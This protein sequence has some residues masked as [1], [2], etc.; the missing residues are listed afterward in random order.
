VSKIIGLWLAVAGGLLTTSEPVRADDQSQIQAQASAGQTPQRAADTAP[1]GSALEEIL[2]TATKT[3]ETSL[4][5]TPL[6]I[7]VFSVERLNDSA[8]LNVKDLVAMTPNL[9]VAQTTANAQIYI[10]GI[11]SNNVFNGSDPDVTVQIDGVYLARAYSQFTDFIDVDRIEVLRG[12]QGTLYGRNAVGG[13]INIISRK[14]SDQFESKVQVTGGTFDLVEAQAYVSGPIIPGTLQASL[15]GNYLNHDDYVDNVVPGKPGVGNADRG[16]LRG[17]LR[18]LPVDNVEMITRADWKKADERYDSFSHVLAPL[19]FAPLAR[20]TVGDYTR[21]A[22]DNPQ[23]LQSKD[24]GVSEEVN[25]TLNSMLSLK[26]LSAYRNSQYWASVD[27][28]A[29]E[30]PIIIATQQDESRQ[31]SQEFDLTAHLEHFDGVMGIYYSQ[32]HETSNLGLDLPPSVPI[33]AARSASALIT[34]DSHARSEAAFAQGTYHLTDALGLTAGIRHTQDRKELNQLYTRVSQNPAT[35]GVASPGFP[36]AANV[37]RTFDATTPKFGIDYQLTPSVLL[38]ASATRG[39]KS[40]GTNWA[41]TNTAALEFGPEQIWSYE[42]GVKSDWFDRRMRVNVTAFKYDYKDLQVQSLIGAG[43]VAIGNAATANVKGLEIE[44]TGKPMPD[45]LLAANFALLDARYG[46]FGA[47]SV[48]S[49]LVPYVSGSPHFTA[50]PTAPTY[51]ASGNRLNAAPRSSVSG[52]AQYDY[53]IGRGK[54]FVRGEY[55]WQDRVFYDP[56]NAAIMSQKPYDLVNLSFGYI[57]DSRWDFR[58]IAKN[59]ADTHYLISI[60]ANGVAP[61][62]LP[63]DPRTV[64]LQV[65][66]SL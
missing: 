56:S 14:P 13:T 26:S 43:V 41:A 60:A 25:I 64:V 51:D 4:Q 27:S 16:G 20:S 46:R 65:S 47:S 38:Y 21:V 3:G 35:L 62:G 57:S 18:F 54:A 10:R 1:S 32:E 8:A 45:L 31:I 30:F 17:Q 61:A 5:K 39:F 9:N 22:L 44:T 58:V 49:V 34:P 23:A 15:T 48:P 55:Y 2:V 28:D 59:V 50:S 12:P 7:S 33:P 11:G 24:W 6:A 36:F 66:K 42:A 40:G 52:S 53:E 63:G 37:S 19:G 29:V